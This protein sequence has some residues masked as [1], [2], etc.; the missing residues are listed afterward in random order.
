MKDLYLINGT[1]NSTCFSSL[2]NKEMIVE[3]KY[4]S[5]E[6]CELSLDFKTDN[7][8][9]YVIKDLSEIVQINR[10]V[11]IGTQQFFQ[12]NNRFSIQ[13]AVES[14]GILLKSYIPSN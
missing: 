4:P 14:A 9:L 5:L 6:I 11:Q 13:K 10:L 3:K 8:N 12:N 7:T 2:N 1:S